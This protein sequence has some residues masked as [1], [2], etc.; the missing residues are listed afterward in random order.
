MQERFPDLAG[1]IQ[2]IADYESSHHRRAIKTEKHHQGMGPSADP[3]QQTEAADI[4]LFPVLLLI[5]AELGSSAQP[6]NVW[7][8]IR[9]R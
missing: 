3:Y 1:G 2:A 9:L 5:R 7:R 8:R 6:A 4:K